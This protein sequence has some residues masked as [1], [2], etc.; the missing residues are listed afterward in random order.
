MKK[1]FCLLLLCV[2]SSN[3]IFADISDD[4]KQALIDLYNSTDGEAWKNSWD[5]KSSYKKWNGVKVVNDHVVEINLFHNNL[6]GTIPESIVK[7]VHLKKLNLAFNSISGELPNG[8][9]L[10]K[11]LRVLKLEMNRIKGTIPNSIGM[12]VNLIE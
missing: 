2:L 3:M 11:E 4:E 9:G 6:S 12:M 1:I 5:I 8:L 7:L 10:L